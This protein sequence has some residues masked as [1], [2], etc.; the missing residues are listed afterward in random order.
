MVFLIKKVG[1]DDRCGKGAPPAYWQRLL[2]KADCS[3]HWPQSVTPLNP[4]VSAPSHGRV[5]WL[6]S[7]R[8][9][10]APPEVAPGQP[11]PWSPALGGAWARG[12]AV[13]GGRMAGP[14]RADRGRCRAPDAHQVPLKRVQLG[15]GEIVRSK[16]T[17]FWTMMVI[18]PKKAP[19]Q[20][21]WG[22]K[23]EGQQKGDFKRKRV[24][25]RSQINE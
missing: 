6:L 18:Y 3:G 2:S 20:L 7:D 13:C 9:F 4:E 14:P 1:R 15:D 19:V 16:A 25:R 5:L 12:G 10:R 22:K 11:R 23:D 17:S 8:N 21:L 24:S